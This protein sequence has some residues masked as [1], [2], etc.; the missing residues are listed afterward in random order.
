MDMDMVVVVWIS[1]NLWRQHL[2]GLPQ[3]QQGMLVMILA[4]IIAVDLQ[5][6]RALGGPFL[7]VGS[8]GNWWSSTE[9]NTTNAWFRYLDYSNDNVNRYSNNKE[10]GLSVRCLRD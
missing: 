4:P 2:G 9:N 10:Y 3:Q 8:N 5:G 1:E 7:N 6:F